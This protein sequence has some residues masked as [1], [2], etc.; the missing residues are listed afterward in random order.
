MKVLIADDHGI[1]RQGLKSLIEEQ[2][3]FEVVGEAADGNKAVEMAFRLKPDIVIMDVTMPNL[4]GVDATRAITQKYPNT[5]VIALSLHAK[6]TIVREMFKA[7]A[8]SY[9]LKSDVFDE[10]KRSLEAIKK[11]ER[12]LNPHVAGLIV[13]EYTASKTKNI[14]SDQKFLSKRERQILQMAADGR[15]IKETA[16]LLHLSTKTTDAHRRNLMAKLGAASVTDLV[17]YAIREGLT[18]LDF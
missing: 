1:V 2:T 14:F 10:V 3:D 16:R 8:Y 11:G 4:N 6:K 12:Y 17:K 5:K 15:S 9:I 13:E 7:G 18:S